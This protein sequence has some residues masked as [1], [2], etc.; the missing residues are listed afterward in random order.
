MTGTTDAAAV[1]QYLDRI[2]KEVVRI[3]GDD[4]SHGAAHALRTK[5]LARR[6]GAV[7]GGDLLVIQAAAL[8]HDIGRATPFSDPGHG[9]RGAKLAAEILERLA[10][11]ADRAL[12]CEIVARHDDEDDG[13]GGPIEL[14]VVK[15]A[16]KLELVRIAPDFLDPSRLVTEEALRQVPYALSLH[17]GQQMDRSDVKEAIGRAKDLLARRR[18]A[19]SGGSS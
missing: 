11:P 14:V 4:Q 9:E 2:K 15:D 19:T 16:D 5:E 3:S 18:A 6:I 13:R 8:L 7:E 10:V 17:Y 1:R 12:I